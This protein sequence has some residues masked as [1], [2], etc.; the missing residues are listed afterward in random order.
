[1]SVAQVSVEQLLDENEAL[2]RRLEEVEDTIR[3]IS[4][5]EVDAFVVERERAEVLTLGAADRPYRLLVETMGQSAAT[6]GADGTVLYA[7][8]R[9]ADL[10]DVPLTKLIGANL[11]EFVPAGEEARFGA[12]LQ[13]GRAGAA[14]VELTLR[15][16]NGDAVPVGVAANALPE[17]AGGVCLV[18]TDLTERQR[19][20][21][22]R[23][24]LAREQAA[25]AELE[26][27]VEART[28]ELRLA[29]EKALQTERLAAIGQ[30]AAGWRTRAATP[31]SA[32]RLACRSWPCASR[33]A[34]RSWRC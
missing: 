6:V 5:G 10:L 11:A 31:C 18:V 9:F 8:R 29:Q 14:E 4:G 23:L 15:R 7:N 20:E 26:R 28:A 21:G 13:H 24:Q 17:G 32:T 27:Q 2:R 19:R 3:A 25:R 16:A 33:R 1:M 12:L 34:R 30:M 22:E